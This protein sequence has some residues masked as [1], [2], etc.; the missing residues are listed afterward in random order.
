MASDPASVAKDK[1][2]PKLYV[3]KYNLEGLARTWD[4]TGLVR[5]RLRSQKRL[6][7]SYDT[8][9]KQAMIVANV[10]TT[11][12]N[13]RVNSFVLSPVL[14]MVRANNDLLPQIDRV[15]QEIQTVY[16][17]NA[18]HVNGDV[19]YH[20]AWSIRHLISLLKGE[21]S[22][23]LNDERRKCKDPGPF[24]RTHQTWTVCLVFAHTRSPT[25]RIRSFA[26]SSLTWASSSQLARLMFVH[27]ITQG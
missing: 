26:T 5:D 10:E 3:G 7:L 8:K 16:W 15:I 19:V 6:F 25:R 14:K 1:G 27:G 13:L 20:E 21:G 2:S 24:P 23:L 18:C 17:A 12:P 4:N 9:L 11:V 22:R